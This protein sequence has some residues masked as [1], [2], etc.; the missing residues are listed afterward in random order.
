ME[1]SYILCESGKIF[2]SASPRQLARIIAQ[3]FPG[4]L[5]CDKICTFHVIQSPQTY[6]EI[7][8]FHLFTDTKTKRR[9]HEKSTKKNEKPENSQ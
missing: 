5:S 3:K 7:Q 2:Y 6:S 4:I 1:E 9:H 8:Y